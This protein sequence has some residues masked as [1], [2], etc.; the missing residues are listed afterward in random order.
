MQEGDL[1]QAASVCDQVIADEPD[2]ARAY[3]MRG[4]VHAQQAEFQSAVNCFHRATELRPDAANYHFNLALAYQ[5]LEQRDEAIASYRAAIECKPDFLEAQNNLGNLLVDDDDPAE[6]IAHFRSLAE[7]HPDEAF[8]HYNLANVLQ[9]AGDYTDSIDA[10][11]RA[12]ELDPDFPSAREN[13]GRALSDVTRYEEAAEVWRDWLKHEPG[14]AVASHMLA[15]LGHAEAPDRCN[16][17]FVKGTFD[18]NFARSFEEQLRRLE[19]NVPKLMADKVA[20]V[21]PDATDLEVLDAGCGTGLCGP[22]LRKYARRLVGVD[23]SPEM[24]VEAKAKQ[25]YDEL[26]EAELSSYF[27][28][29]PSKYDLMICADTLCY[30]GD[31]SLV[32]HAVPSMLKPGGSFLFSVEKIAD[33]EEAEGDASGE[34]GAERS[35]SS[36]ELQPNGRYSHEEDYVRNV[37][38]E[39]NLEIKSFESCVLRKERGRDVIGFVVVVS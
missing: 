29:D 22:D 4:V 3:L 27:S 30:F 10:F 32:M 35:S 33:E 11:R 5:H 15:A 37:L 16:D 39:S 20:S 14:N 17:E 38:A 7:T 34:T 26:V 18:H 36:Y 12:I 31:L 6:A 8:V 1:D 23:L 2:N 19:Y 21:V 24:L 9:D 25:V 13:L 28:Q